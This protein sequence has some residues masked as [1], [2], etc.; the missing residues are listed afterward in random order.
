MRDSSPPPQVE[1]AEK[2]QNQ[3]VPLVVRLAAWYEGQ[4]ELARAVEVLQ[5]R[6]NDH[7]HAHDD[8]EDAARAGDD[9][10]RSI[11]STDEVDGLM[12]LQVALD[13]IIR[14]SAARKKRGG[15]L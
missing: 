2:I 9:L 7:A 14:R 1:Q 3:V 4:G 5:A 15:V 6:L 11:M 8:D 10:G 12:C 13:E